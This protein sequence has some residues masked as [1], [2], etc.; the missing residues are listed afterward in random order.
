LALGQGT[1]DTTVQM[2]AFADVI[3]KEAKL[4]HGPSA[5]ALEAGSRQARFARANFCDDIRAGLH[6]VCDGVKEIGAALAA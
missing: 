5:L 4:P 2:G 1:V 3:G 6:L